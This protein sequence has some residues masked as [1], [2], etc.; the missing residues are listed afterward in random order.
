MESWPPIGCEQFSDKN[1]FC[2]R[3]QEH[4]KKVTITDILKKLKLDE[5]IE[6]P[7]YKGSKV[8]IINP[9]YGHKC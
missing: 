1:N 8:I 3:A 2:P 9:S 4:K 7:K 5:L 6:N